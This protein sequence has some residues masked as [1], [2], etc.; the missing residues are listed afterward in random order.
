MLDLPWIKRVTA[1]SAGWLISVIVL[2]AKCFEASN[3]R[4]NLYFWLSL[5]LSTELKELQSR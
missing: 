5:F 1:I 2:S 3:N 4:A